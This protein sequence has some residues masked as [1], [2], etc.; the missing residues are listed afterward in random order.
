MNVP[1][2]ASWLGASVAAPPVDQGR[3]ARSGRRALG[4]EDA[5][6]IDGLERTALGRTRERFR[7]S[8]A[9]P[10]RAAPQS[11]SDKKV[12]VTEQKIVTAT[13]MDSGSVPPTDGATSKEAAAAEL[14]GGLASDPIRRGRTTS[15][16]APFSQGRGPTSALP[17]TESFSLR[18]G[19]MMK[20][21]KI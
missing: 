5:A 18:D 17:P 4:V 14:E 8:R 2:V 19:T 15:T 21:Q 1:S 9:A 6:G 11:H 13:F 20:P 16:A 12:A 3:A 7:A 10:G